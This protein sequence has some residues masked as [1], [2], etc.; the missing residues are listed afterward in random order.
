[1]RAG[2][3]RRTGALLSAAG[4]A[5]G[6]VGGCGSGTSSSSGGAGGKIL[7]VCTGGTGVVAN[8][9]P[10]AAASSLVGT[11]GMIYE[12]LFYFSTVR[13]GDIQPQLGTAYSFADDG[14]TL[15]ITTR[16][17]VKWSDGQ[18]FSADD[19]AFTFNL[20]KDNAKLNLGGLPIT[21][22]TATDATHVKLTFSQG[23]YTKLSNIAGGTAMVP[24]HLWASL[25]DPAAFTND[26]PVGTGPF[27]V[28][29]VSQQNWVLERNPN[30][31]EAGKPKIKG[32]RFIQFGGND[33]T[34]AALA[35]GQ[36]DWCGAFIQNIDKQFISKDP[37]HNHYINESQSFITNLIPNLDKSVLGDAAARK[38]VSMAINRDQL[39]KQAF[40]GYGKPVN[41]SQL[42]VPLLNDYIKPEYQQSSL[43][44]YNQQQAEQTLQQ[45]GWAKGADGV[46]A[47]GGKRLSFTVM[48]VQGYS[49]YIS[50]LQIMSQELKAAGIEM[51]TTEV[52][53]NAFNVNQQ[54]G[55][56]DVIMTNVYSDD[57]TPYSFYARAFDSKRTAPVGK[58]ADSNF[59]RFRDATVDEA[60]RTIEQTAPDQKDAIKAQ[61]LKIQDVIASQFPYI[62]I[63]QS[64]A[65]I[66]YRT[67]NATNFPTEE[68][69]YAFAAP[70]GWWGPGIVAKNLEPAK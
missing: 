65:L 54:T 1:M 43:L 45:A 66:E 36:I 7:N 22:A 2:R 46:Y 14:K 50:A 57:A 40:A 38:A 44:T 18:P 17:G 6:L 58:Q 69:H 56:F 30:Y 41:V 62:P 16:P 34:T 60:L 67:V 15:N 68:N 51:K 37:A 39:I 5:I 64:S 61:I 48:V 12:P 26:K 42:P 27:K 25:T 4:L 70:F 49:D 13:V 23:V 8:F 35:A 21:G 47:K 24:K 53:Y 31:W 32:V 52:S 3:L 59:G 55:A 29:S 63:Q 33:S 28:S 20:I 10:F 11:Q 19:V 9:N